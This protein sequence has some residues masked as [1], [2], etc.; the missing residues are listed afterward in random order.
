MTEIEC[1]TDGFAELTLETDD[2]AALE[3]FYLEVFGLRVLTREPDRVWLA[4]GP[5]ARLGL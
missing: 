2:L 3:R 4:A 1:P 5:H